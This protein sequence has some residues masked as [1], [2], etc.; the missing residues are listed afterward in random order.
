MVLCNIMKYYEKWQRHTTFSY[1]AKMH[2][3]KFLKISNFFSFQAITICADLF[4][5]GK[6][7][8]P[9]TESMRNLFTKM[10][11]YQINKIGHVINNLMYRSI[12]FI[13]VRANSNQSNSWNLILHIL[14]ESNTLISIHV[15]RS[16][17]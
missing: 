7:Y 11:T 10:Q 6:I 4:V 5:Q 17:S 14:I 1:A 13:L 9:H 12:C 2:E 15:Q 8:F 3:T 16:L